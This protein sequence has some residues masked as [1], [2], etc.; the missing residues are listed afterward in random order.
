MRRAAI[1]ILGALLSLWP[2]CLRAQ[3]VRVAA[4]S[5][6]QFAMAE[7]AK[8][9]EKET[10]TK[11]ELSFGSSGN[12][13]AQIQNAAPFNLFFSADRSYPERLIGA[14]IAD[15]KSLYIYAL[16]RLA[17]W[18]PSEAGLK[19][20]E[21]GFSALTDPRVQKIAIANPELA[22][23]GRAAVAALQK[24][25]VYEQVKSK[26]VFGEN[27]SQAA[28]FVQSGNAQVGMIAL[29]L[30]LSESM[31]GGERWVVPADYYPPV[32]QAAVLIN[33]TGSKT[34]A[35]GFLEFVKSEAGRA[36]LGR[37]GFAAPSS[38]SGAENKP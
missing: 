34:E 27:I 37:Y 7:L 15:R 3:A 13:F 33:G 36:I 18:A 17:L 14:G 19:L 22:P 16:G 31:K 10:G 38:S 20:V 2:S 25:G 12:L 4:A 24:A 32:E 5:D 28:Q 30:A 23:Y 26:L 1:T 29:S 11:V 8:R 6:L 21:K 9:Y 35:A